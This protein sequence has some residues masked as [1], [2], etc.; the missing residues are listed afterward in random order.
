MATILSRT[1]S[2]TGCSGTGKIGDGGS[3]GVACASDK[4]GGALRVGFPE[5]HPVNTHPMIKRQIDVRMS[6]RELT[7]VLR[8][9]WLTGSDLKPHRSPAV[10][11][12]TLV[13]LSRVHAPHAP[14]SFMYCTHAS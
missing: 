5:A 11:C 2:G 1:S 10:A 13:R 7:T 12:S 6:L 4:Q 8:R 14:A 9:G 3:D